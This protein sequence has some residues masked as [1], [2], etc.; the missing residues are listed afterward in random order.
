MARYV[1]INAVRGL[2]TLF[3]VSVLVF[4]LARLTG[5]PLDVL[6]PVDM[7][8]EDEEALRAQ[9]GLDGTLPEQYI[10]FVGNAMKGDFGPSFKY[11]TETAGS[12]IL[13]RLP[14]SIKLG[15][16]S[17][18]LTVM[19]G[20][21]LGILSAVRR[22]S[23]VDR[24]AKGFA[25]FGQ[26]V[27]EFWL[28]IVLI[29]FVA[30]RWHVVPTSGIT[31]WRSYILPSIVISIFGIAALLR[32]FRSAMLETMGS[33]YVKLARLKGVSELKVIWK[34]ALKPASIAPLTFFGGIVVRMLTGATVVE[35]VFS[36]PGAGLLAY[37][38]ANAR[39]FPVVQALALFTAAAI[40]IMNLLID[41]TYAYVDPRV[42]LGQKAVV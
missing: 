3:A 19:I 37:E 16:V 42:R 21:P 27:P 7:S 20:V 24:V 2:L 30:V 39:D 26:S 36:W 18:I 23:L 31:D 8:R 34:H 12:V 17:T 10:A 1:A 13:D 35:I 25:L 32:L 14:N 40:V 41:I 15:V 29:W 33:E 6:A 22:G 9:W 4:F 11:P 38:A 28:A 5:D